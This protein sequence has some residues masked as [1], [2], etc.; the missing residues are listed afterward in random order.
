MA[1]KRTSERRK[2]A[3]RPPP[4]TNR[5][6]RKG[7]RQSKRPIDRVLGSLKNVQP[8]GD[9]HSAL[10]PA[11]ADGSSSLSI[12]EDDDGTVAVFCHAGC[13]TESVLE[14]IGLEFADL[15]P[16]G[17]DRSACRS[18]DACRLPTPP[19]ARRKCVK[20][21]GNT[22]TP[23]AVAKP[24]KRSKKKR[25]RVLKNAKGS[26]KNWALLIGTYKREC[27]SELLKQLAK[28]LGVSTASL[29][30]LHVGW[31]P[32]DEC[33]TFPELTATG[34]ICG[35]VRRYDDG[36]K[37]AM[38]DSKRGLYLPV[39]W[40][41]HEGPIVIVEGATDTAAGWD[42][43]FAVV[44]RPNAKGGGKSLA[45]LLA[46]Q[47]EDRDIIVLGEFDP[48]ADGKWPGRDGAEKVATELAAA[49]ERPVKWA[50]PPGRA[51]DLRRWLIRERK[52]SDA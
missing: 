13:E 48:K 51:K 10:C 30:A 3:K 22:D 24:I 25:A 15:F 8:C 32:E 47:P 16:T 29:R 41:Q 38:A 39:G 21:K 17:L 7:L 46:G 35:I 20:K 42:L 11:H 33:F 40:E 52:R 18:D 1:K 28:L 6:A 4:P 26:K 31:N 36:S 5:A 23:I 9:G 12:G 27:T 37:K 43:G 19:A 44:G 14:A 50:L 45:T 49:L 2:T 34:K